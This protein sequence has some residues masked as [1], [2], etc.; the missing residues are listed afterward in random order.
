MPLPRVLILHNQ[1]VLSHDHPDA[2][3]EHEILETVEFVDGCLR[4]AGFPVGCLGVSHDPAALVAGCQRF[5]PDVV[6]NLFEGTGDDGHNEAFAAGLLHWM[7]IPFTGC[8]FTTLTL[9]RSKHLTKHL[10][11][12]AGLPT[13]DFMVI[14]SD[15]VP[16]CHLDWPVIVKPGQQDASLGLDQ[17][18]VVT[19][20]EQLELRVLRLLENFGPPV[21]VEEFIRG[22]E[23]NVGV[24]ELP[25]LTV[26]PVSEILFMEDRP[27]YWPIVTYDAKWRPESEDYLATPP[28]YPA[29]VTPRLGQRLADIAKAAFR[30]TG[31]RDYARVDFRVRPGGKPHILEV[32]PNPDFN[33]E[34]GMG[35]SLTSA[36]IS[37]PQFA[38]Q[39]VWNAVARGP[40]ASHFDVP[41]TLLQ[42]A[43]S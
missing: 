16:P 36:G 24:V 21:L 41:S 34:A 15:C 14:E 3:S 26:L 33:P 11:R 7:K 25:E 38:V 19:D 28:T 30:L 9:A 42:L 31:C 20:Q 2:A 10:L 6:F 5:E 22:R 43:P 4:E 32:N 18:S 8:P 23:F 12:S 13:A 1:P 17:G 27:G 39:L 35:A 37:H 29:K 40:R